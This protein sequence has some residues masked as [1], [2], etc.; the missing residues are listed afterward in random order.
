MAYVCLVAR[1]LHWHAACIRYRCLGKVQQISN[2][3]GDCE[4]QNEKPKGLL[5]YR[6]LDR[7]RDH[8]HYRRD[9]YP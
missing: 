8:R 1:I 6:T 2:I 3:L 5:A 9:R 7:R 4:L